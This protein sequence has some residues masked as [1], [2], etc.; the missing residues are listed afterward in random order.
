[1]KYVVVLGDGMADEPIA[2][3][4]G[5]TPLAYANTPALDALSK[6]SEIGMV[7]TIPKGMKPGSDTANLSVMG[8]DPR[9]YYSGRSPLE[10]LSIGVPMKDTDIAL[11]CNIVTLSEEEGI[12][13]AK[14]RILD[15]SSGEIETEDC[16]V[17]LRAVME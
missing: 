14:R 6:K 17:L 10:A 15:L 4:N 12:P 9:K 5:R 7:S 16:A 2:R 1:M 13:F 11:R 8:Y 3:L